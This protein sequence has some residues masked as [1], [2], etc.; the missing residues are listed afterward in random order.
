MLSR[1]RSDVEP[2]IKGLFGRDPA[3]IIQAYLV[4]NSLTEY[5]RFELDSES[6][7]LEADTDGFWIWGSMSFVSPELG[8]CPLVRWCTRNQPKRLPFLTD[9]DLM[10]E[11]RQ[12]FYEEKNDL[13][14]V[15][16]SIFDNDIAGVLVMEAPKILVVLKDCRVFV[17]RDNVVQTIHWA[18]ISLGPPLCHVGDNR[19]L[20]TC[21]ETTVCL[22]SL[23]NNSLWNVRKMHSHSTPVLDVALSTSGQCLSASRELVV[24]SES[25]G[26]EPVFL[27][28]VDEVR[29]AA[30][31]K[32]SERFGILTQKSLGFFS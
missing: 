16:G 24:Y 14:I 8:L 17:V 13:T 32:N 18:C 1:T 26:S 31:M 10:F 11:G 3:H 6:K 12:L 20:G 25:I 2:L 9:W 5:Y 30:F 28:Q 23:Q 19:F 21:N 27:P 15:H 4:C 7:T 22:M 29:A